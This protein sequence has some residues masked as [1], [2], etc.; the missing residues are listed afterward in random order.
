MK[1]EL[2]GWLARLEAMANSSRFTE[3]QWELLYLLSSSDK[4]PEIPPRLRDVKI[5]VEMLRALLDED[6]NE[7][8]GEV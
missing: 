7:P 5:P 1:K 8:E 6:D 2:E 4:R 3:E